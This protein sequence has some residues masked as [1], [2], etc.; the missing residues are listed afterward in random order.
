MKG[1]PA[2]FIILPNS[3][4]KLVAEACNLSTSEI[5]VAQKE[6]LVYDLTNLTRIENYLIIISLICLTTVVPSLHSVYSFT[7]SMLF[8]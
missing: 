6:R 8:F 3:M 4:S 2:C 5:P 7:R 1:S